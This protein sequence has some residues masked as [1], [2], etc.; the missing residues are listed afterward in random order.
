MVHQPR[1]NNI[2]NVIAPRIYLNSI[3]L[4]MHWV[5]LSHLT[6]QFEIRLNDKT[7]RN[8]GVNYMPLR[9]ENFVYFWTYSNN[10]SYRDW[11]LFSLKIFGTNNKVHF[12]LAL[13]QFYKVAFT[14]SQYNVLI[15]KNHHQLCIS[16][17][18]NFED[19]GV[20]TNK[21]LKTIK[22]VIYDPCV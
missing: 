1:D 12:S 4:S 19:I 15:S 13:L 8:V 10:S 3:F 20:L 7:L 2:N 17:S 11:F 22:K 5:E 14:Y 6:Q 16:L 9:Q 18:I 21:T